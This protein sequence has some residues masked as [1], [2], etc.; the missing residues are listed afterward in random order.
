MKF[1]NLSN[2]T[3]ANLV[4][5]EDVSTPFTRRRFKHDKTRDLHSKFPS[6]SFTLYSA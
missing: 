6:T 5:M 4:M 3:K 2:E 1:R